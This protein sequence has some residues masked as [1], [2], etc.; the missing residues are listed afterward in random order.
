MEYIYCCTVLRTEEYINKLTH[1][2][3]KRLTPVR[4]FAWGG[5]GSM[6]TPQE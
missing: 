3:G 4:G 6:V 5:A 2:V 1:R